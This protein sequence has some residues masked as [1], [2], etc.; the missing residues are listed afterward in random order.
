MGWETRKRGGRYYTR[1]RKVGGR[2][3]REYIGGG[4]LGEAVAECDAQ[5]RAERRAAAAC[6]QRERDQLAALDALMHDFSR[7]VDIQ[8]RAALCAAGFHQHDRGEW[9]RERAHNKAAYN[10]AAYNKAARNEGTDNSSK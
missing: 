4:T 6:W 10:K 1:S 9:R 5:E 2:V 7:Q 8:M 3:V